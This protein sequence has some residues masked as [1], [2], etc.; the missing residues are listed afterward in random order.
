VC[1]QKQKKCRGWLG[2]AKQISNGRAD[3]WALHYLVLPVRNDEIPH[4]KGA[5]K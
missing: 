1:V 2:F 4:L 5:S 3:M